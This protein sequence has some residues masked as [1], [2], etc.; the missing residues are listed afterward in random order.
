MYSLVAGARRRFAIACAALIVVVAT[1]APAPVAAASVQN[2]SVQSIVQNAA[3]G[4]GSVVIQVANNVNVSTEIAVGAPS[5]AT[6][7]TLQVINQYA[8]GGHIIQLARNTNVLTI[9]AVALNHP[10]HH[11]H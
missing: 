2:G 10:R 3:A 8:V 7:G 9:H 1:V 11:K 5:T 4:P 6:N